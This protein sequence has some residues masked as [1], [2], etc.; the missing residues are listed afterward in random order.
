MVGRIVDGGDGRIKRERERERETHPLVQHPR[1]CGGRER[2]HAHGAARCW[3]FKWDPLRGRGAGLR[4]ARGE[5]MG[6]RRRTAAL[7]GGE[8]TGSAGARGLSHSRRGQEGE[9]S[10]SRTQRGCRVWRRQ[11]G[12]R[13]STKGAAGRRRR[14]ASRGGRRRRCAFF[15]R[16]SSSVPLT[17]S[18]N[19]SNRLIDQSTYYQRRMPAPLASPA[20]GRAPLARTDEEAIVAP[21]P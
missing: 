16:S 17:Q 8:R 13:R 19:Q 15:S 5:A 9:S 6:G 18:I 3:W 20:F 2:A 12:A 10:S 14:G 1:C 7:F 11:N 4:G 21:S